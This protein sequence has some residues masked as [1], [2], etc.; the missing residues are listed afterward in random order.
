ME[1][2]IKIMQKI[3][4]YLILIKLSHILIGIYITIFVH[5]KR[6]FYFN[7]DYFTKNIQILFGSRILFELSQK[8]VLD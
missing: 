3:Y 2:Y 5:M 8:F 7:F 4:K 1:L 6:I